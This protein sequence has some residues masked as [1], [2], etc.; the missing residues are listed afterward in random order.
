MPKEY[1]KRTLIYDWDK[2]PI[3]FDI[4][5]A[6]NLLALTYEKVRRLCVAGVIPAHKISEHTWRINKKEFMEFVGVKE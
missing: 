4:A 5:Y 2:V 1:N 6:A 3:M